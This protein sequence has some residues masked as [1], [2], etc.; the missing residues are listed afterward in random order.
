MVP[1]RFLL[2][3]AFC[4]TAFFNAPGARA[5]ETLRIAAQK[6]GTLS[7]ELAVIAIRKPDRAAGV[8]LTVSEYASPEAG[9]IALLGDSADLIVADLTWVARERALGGAFVFHPFS[10]ALGAIMAPA[11]APIRNLADLKGR[12]LGVAGGAGDK[13]WLLLQAWARQRGVDIKAQSQI[14]FGAPPLLAAKAAQGELDAVLT[15]WNFCAELEAQGFQRGIEMEQVERDLG[16]AAP[17]ALIGYVFR[18]EFA[19][20]NGSLLQR[21]FSAAQE[22]RSLLANDSAAWEVI[23]PRLRQTDSATLSTLRKRYGEGLPVRPLEEE[24]RDAR[25][26][27]KVLASIGGSEFDKAFSALDKGVYWRPGAGE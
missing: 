24:M 26:L 25:L 11:S 23:K 15:Y 1:M 2:F 19:A 14:V 21:Y 27:L 8:D 17:A 13:S 9:K 18:E 12:K 10:S 5:G 6:T 20:R 7:W 16:A 4:L 22:A 3:A